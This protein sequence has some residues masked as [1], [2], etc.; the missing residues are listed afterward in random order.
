[1]LNVANSYCTNCKERTSDRYMKCSK[2]KTVSYCSKRCQ[3]D[4]WSVHEA[5]CKLHTPGETWGIRVL[6]NN[7]TTKIEDSSQYFKHEL[8]KGSDHPIYTHGER[9]PVTKRIGIPLIIYSTGVR[10]PDAT[11]LNEIVVKLRVEAT[12]GFAP[13]T[14]LQMPGECLV[15]RED[16][17]PLTREMLETVYGFMRHLMSYPILDEGWASWQGLLNPSVW[18]MY[19]KKYYEDQKAA[20]RQGF[21]CFFP[22]VD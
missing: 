8:I 6:S 13:D 7:W 18:Q 12:D 15:I 14:W 1:M 11:G 22:L 17:K 3:L 16:R 21:G 20:G 2:C 9:C 4:H 19:A 10:N 5:M